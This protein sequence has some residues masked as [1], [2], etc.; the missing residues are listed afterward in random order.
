MKLK[1]A[2]ALSLVGIIALTLAIL[3]PATAQTDSTHDPM[4]DSG[5]L[6]SLPNFVIGPRKM[7]DLLI[8]DLETLEVVEVIPLKRLIYVGDPWAGTEPENPAYVNYCGPSSTRLALSIYLTDLPSL[9]EIGACEN[10]NPDWGVIMPNVTRCLNSYLNGSLY[11]TGSA[12]SKEEFFDWV[13][14]DIDSGKVMLTG[15][16]TGE[17][18]GWKTNDVHHIVAIV[19]YDMSYEQSNDIQ[20]YYVDVSSSLAGYSGPYFNTVDLGWLWHQ[21]RQNNS[22]SW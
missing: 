5:T 3:S 14:T 20:I 15:L 11:Q 8:D 21:V 18:P 7:A 17:I 22:Q 16:M 4:T 12:T 10:I 19:G 2:P 13:K 6:A 1:F 9:D